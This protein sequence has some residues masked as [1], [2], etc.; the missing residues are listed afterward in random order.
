MAKLLKS[1]LDKVSAGY[2]VARYGECVHTVIDIINE[3]P[4]MALRLLPDLPFVWA[5]VVY[6]LRTEMV[7][8]LEDLL[9]R[10][11]PLTILA[12]PNQDIAERAAGLAADILGWTAMDKNAEIKHLMMH[13]R[14]PSS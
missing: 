5:E 4:G 13:W 1:G 2:L 10:R 14:L 6:C 11:I 7:V 9:R 8:H 3:M 12:K